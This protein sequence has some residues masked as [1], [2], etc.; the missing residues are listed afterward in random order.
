MDTKKPQSH[1]EILALWPKLPDVARDLEFNYIA[2]YK[3]H[4][5]NMIPPEWWCLLVDAA[6]NRD[7]E[8]TFK[9]LAE[10]VKGRKTKLSNV[11]IM[12]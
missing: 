10:T 5:R 11:A 4:E 12:I 8:V 2:V 6:H 3:W 9:L 7:L 1:R